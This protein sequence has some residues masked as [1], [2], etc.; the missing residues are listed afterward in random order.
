MK[1]CVVA[2]YWHSLAFL[3]RHDFRGNCS[4]GHPLKSLTSS[5]ESSEKQN[6]DILMFSG[7]L[8]CGVPISVEITG[9]LGALGNM[10]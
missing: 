3:T 6:P 4:S 10:R 8:V 9:F 5:N 1:V 7:G 2:E